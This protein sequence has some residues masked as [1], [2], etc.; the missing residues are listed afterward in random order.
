[1]QQ[2]R[3]DL[4]L[5]GHTHGGQ[6]IIPGFG[7]APKLL[8]TLGRFL[9]KSIRCWIPLVNECSHIVQHWEWAKG[10]HQVGANQL[11]VNR[12]LGTYAPGR[13][14]CPPEVTVITLV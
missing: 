4:Q 13:F 7:P 6:I 14:L 9:P 3:V 12:G 11:Y 5:S 8:Y 2:W 1:L 10:M